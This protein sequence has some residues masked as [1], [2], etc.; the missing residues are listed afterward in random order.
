[1]NRSPL[2]RSLVLLLVG[3]LCAVAAAPPAAVA[4]DEAQ[5][6]ATAKTIDILY[7]RGNSKITGNIISE[8]DTEVVIEVI[9]GNIKPQEMTFPKSQIIYIEYDQ[10]LDDAREDETI[11]TDDS[12]DPDAVPVVLLNLDGRFGINISKTPVREALEA[13]ERTE[14][15]YVIVKLDCR[16]GNVWSLQDVFDVFREYIHD[17]WEDS[18]PDVVF[19]VETALEG[20]GLLPFVDEDIYFTRD[21]IMGGIT[22][23]DDEIK[24]VNATDMI[25][26]KWISATM[27]H[28]E[29]IAIR[30]GYDTRLV[31]AMVIEEYVLSVDLVGGQPVYHEDTSGE[32]LLTDSG[33]GEFE[34]GISSGGTLAGSMIRNDVLNLDDEMAYRLRVSD[35]T[36]DTVE[37]LMDLLGVRKFR[38]I[39]GLPQKKI[40]RWSEGIERDVPRIRDRLEEIQRRRGQVRGDYPERT[41]LRGSILRE[42]EQVMALVRRYEEVLDPG[43]GFMMRLQLL[44]DE[45]KREQKIDNESQRP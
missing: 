27:G 21:G 33:Q 7:L 26:A 11:I 13:V 4:D 43:Q 29:G 22:N 9:I 45:I 1:M 24:K 37:Q 16:E 19:W 3:G 35:G 39:D 34:D 40:A 31:K 6:K 41:R 44:H 8:T 2:I 28:V 20:A 23:F 30:G 18:G 32:F 12:I 17:K 14:A 15:E 5:A 36:A 42:I 10:P 38:L 25:K